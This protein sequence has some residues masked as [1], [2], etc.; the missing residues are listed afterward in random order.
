MLILNSKLEVL[1]ILTNTYVNC[2][3]NIDSEL[4][5]WT[6]YYNTDSKIK[7]EMQSMKIYN[8]K[9]NK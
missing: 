5:V 1:N 7:Y 3:L 4:L 8:Q 9:L 6:D 2:I